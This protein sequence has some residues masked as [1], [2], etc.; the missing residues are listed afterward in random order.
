MIAM[1]DEIFTVGIVGIGQGGAVGIGN[2]APRFVIDEQ[3]MQL[4]QLTALGAEQALQ[5]WQPGRV[6]AVAFE[7]FHQRKQQRI[8]LL[9]RRLR[10]RGQ[11]LRKVGHRHFLVMQMV[12]ARTPR[13]PDHDDNHGQAHC[14]KQYH[15]GAYLDPGTGLFGDQRHAVAQ[16]F[17]SVFD[18][19][20]THDAP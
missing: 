15:R 20:V 9:D 18:R 12:L 14:N 8:G 7:A 4:T 19:R 1:E 3:A 11:G 6:E 17:N 13:F 5:M 2:P 10:L 16:L